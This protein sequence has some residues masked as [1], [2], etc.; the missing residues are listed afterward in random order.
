MPA[1][2]ARV[3]IV[4][5]SMMSWWGWDNGGKGSATET[6]GWCTP[7]GAADHDGVPGTAAHAATRSW[8]C[9]IP[10]GALL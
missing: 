7:L 10:L 4:K 3:G 2:Y 1:S 8:Q 6:P 5:D 9:A